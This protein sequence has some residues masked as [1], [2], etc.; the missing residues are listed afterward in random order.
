VVRWLGGRRKLW[1]AEGEATSAGGEVGEQLDAGG[2][3]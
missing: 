2:I 1:H 3:L